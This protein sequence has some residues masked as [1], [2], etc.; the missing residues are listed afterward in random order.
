MYM[1]ICV[2]GCVFECVC[3]HMCV[4]VCT[5]IYMCVCV[6]T[7]CV[8]V[9]V[10]AH[11]YVCVCVCVCTCVCV[12]FHKT[13]IMPYHFCRQSCTSQNDSLHKLLPP[14]QRTDILTHSWFL[15]VCSCPSCR[16]S[17]CRSATCLSSAKRIV[18]CL[19]STG[20]RHAPSPSS[21]TS[22]HRQTARLVSTG[23][24]G[25]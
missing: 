11:V 2:Y 18:W 25:A 21:G 17:A 13:S 1:H 8:C 19:S 15:S 7:L 22:P 9:C 10:C 14:S 3:A 4:C 24:T 20:P 23:G 16:W 5:Y 6:C 12:C